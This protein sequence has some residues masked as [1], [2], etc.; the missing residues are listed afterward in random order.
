MVC[1]YK[2][3]H[4]KVPAGVTRVLDD[5]DGREFHPGVLGGAT[6]N[7]MLLA[8]KGGEN[9][10]ESKC[11]CLTLVCPLRNSGSSCRAT[12]TDTHKTAE[13]LQEGRVMAVSLACRRT[14]RE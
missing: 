8:K 14:V 9:T 4:S 3:V 2:Q 13:H 6:R 11:L 1:L 12:H 10:S 5:L 7:G